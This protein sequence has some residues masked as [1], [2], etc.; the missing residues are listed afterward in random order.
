MMKGRSTSSRRL[1][2]AL[3]LEFFAELGGVDFT[4][5]GEWE[6]GEDQQPS[7]DFPG[8]EFFAEE[9]AGFFQ[10]KLSGEGGGDRF[11]GLGMGNDV[12]VADGGEAF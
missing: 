1:R 8:G 4:S 3:P 5:S 7:R 11:G 10:G 6:F 2:R 12:R 9:G